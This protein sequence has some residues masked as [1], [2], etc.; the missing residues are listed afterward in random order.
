MDDRWDD[1]LSTGKG[2]KRKRLEES[3]NSES[4]NTNQQPD[5]KKQSSQRETN[6]PRRESFLD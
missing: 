5:I 4:P 6:Q 2:C 3:N 1:L